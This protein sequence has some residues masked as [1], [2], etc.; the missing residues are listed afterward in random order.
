MIVYNL[1]PLLAGTFPRWLP[2]VER[3]EAMG[4]DWI[5]LNPVQQPGTSGSIYSIADSFALNPALVDPADSRPAED[6]LRAVIDETRSR[7]LR[8]MVDLVINHCAQDSAVVAS[9]PE[10]FCRDADGA[11]AKAFCWEDGTKVVWEDL[12]QFDHTGTADPE[13]LY[14]YCLSVAEYLLD[15]GCE[16]F[17][18]DAAY[19]VPAALWRR[20]IVDLK[21]RAPG[22]V[23][24][25]E[26]LGC[27][28]SEALAT[29]GAGFDYV[30]NSS[31]WW[32]F[33][34]PWLLQQYELIREV[35]ATIAF[36]ESHDTPRLAQEVNGNADALKLRYLFSALSSSGC[37]IPI[38]FEF[39]FRRPLHVVSSRPKDWETTGVDLRG[40]IRSVNQVKAAHPVFQE[41]APIVVMPSPDPHIVAF[42][43]ASASAVQE[44]LLFLNTDPVGRHS[45]VLP[46]VRSL[47][48][49]QLSPLDVSPEFRMEIVPTGP[50]EYDFGPGQGLVFVAPGASRSS[51]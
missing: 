15:L 9:H 19:K 39:A 44:A 49:F 4:F 18:C 5:L 45:V 43:K 1:F 34:D 21:R 48:Q 40:F 6:Q 32:N 31:K 51:S 47:L 23:F 27:T 12:A 13:G 25:A 26:T 14:R 42:W 10:W 41:D 35:A 11:V 37:M 16:G 50:F 20:L 29:A 28:P 33:R 17:R 2:H 7:G 3:A 30:F 36:P 38:G 8:T 46:D 24:V 22:A